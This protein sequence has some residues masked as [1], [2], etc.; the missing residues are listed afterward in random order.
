[1]AFDVI[2]QPLSVADMPPFRRH[3]ASGFAI[4]LAA[5]PYTPPPAFLAAFFDAADLPLLPLNML[6]PLLMPLTLMPPPFRCHG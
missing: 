5:M 4:S 6:L 1:M 3:A 2:F